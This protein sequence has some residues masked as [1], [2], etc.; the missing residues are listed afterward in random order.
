[1]LAGAD[2]AHHP[3]PPLTTCAPHPSQPP[4]PQTINRQGRGAASG[5][6]SAHA[7]QA[8]QDD[9]KV[10]K[11]NVKSAA[12]SKGSAGRQG[13]QGRED[14]RPVVCAAAVERLTGASLRARPRVDRRR[15]ATLA[16]C[17]VRLGR[18]LRTRCAARTGWFLVGVP[19]SLWST[20]ADERECLFWG[21]WGCVL[22]RSSRRSDAPLCLLSRC[23]R[24][25]GTSERRTLFWAFLSFTQPPLHNP[26]F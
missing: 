24:N 12:A 26:F 25:R 20:V 13:P 6:E 21:R 14:H 18:A 15:F 10:M 3:A 17:A 1:M 16:A 9:D 8:A 5:Y 19:Q 4:R 22:A 2:G 11:E 7:L 23:V